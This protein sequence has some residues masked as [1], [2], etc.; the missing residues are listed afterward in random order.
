MQGS[1]GCQ[2][3]NRGELA[4]DVDSRGDHYDNREYIRITFRI[5]CRRDVDLSINDS[6]HVKQHHVNHSDYLS[7]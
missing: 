3:P 4:N 6:V 5:A 2:E 7:S 1:C